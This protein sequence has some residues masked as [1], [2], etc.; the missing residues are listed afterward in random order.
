MYK[1]KSEAR[2]NKESIQKTM[3]DKIMLSRRNS[4]S[5]QWVK[6]LSIR[7]ADHHRPPFE[8]HQDLPFFRD[9]ELILSSGELGPR[10]R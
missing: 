8:I 7:L 9:F 3:V 10:Q 4:T 6:L 5:I 1:D 2:K